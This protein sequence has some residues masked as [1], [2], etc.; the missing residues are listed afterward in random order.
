MLA[1]RRIQ[2][3]ILKQHITYKC[4]IFLIAGCAIKNAGIVHRIVIL[5]VLL[6]RIATCGIMGHR[7]INRLCQRSIGCLAGVSERLFESG[8]FPQLDR[9]RGG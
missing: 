4:S 8:I 7:H 6:M 2:I 9:I 3:G 1:K 5:L